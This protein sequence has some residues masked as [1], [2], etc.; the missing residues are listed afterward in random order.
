MSRALRAALA[1]AAVLAAVFAPA[2]A[3]AAQADDPA[4]AC[5]SGGFAGY[6]DPATSAAFAN[7][8]SCVS[9]VRHG[10]ALKPVVPPVVQNNV[11]QIVYDPAV[12]SCGIHGVFIG[13]P[14]AVYQVT[15]LDPAGQVL[16]TEERT[17]LSD[18]S[19]TADWSAQP[20]GTPL[21]V[22]IGGQRFTTPVFDCPT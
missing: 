13:Q 6:V 8:G 5:K 1:G 20:T 22:T 11:W 17:G 4:T 3:S 12:Q 7:Q 19:F 10:G 16:Y 14:G 18:G 2:A 15:F 21:T 9:F